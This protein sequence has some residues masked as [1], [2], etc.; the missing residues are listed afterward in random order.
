MIM[1]TPDT[2]RLHLSGFP[3][4]LRGIKGA[5]FLLIIGVAIRPDDFAIRADE[6]RGDV[7]DHMHWF[8]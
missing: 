8:I 1:G 4:N 5:G 3:D 2:G 7:L 6:E